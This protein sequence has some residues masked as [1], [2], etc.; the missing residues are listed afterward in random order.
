MQQKLKGYGRKAISDSFKFL[1]EKCFRTFSCNNELIPNCWRLPILSLILGT[2]I[3]LVTEYLGVLGISEEPSRLTKYAGLLGRKGVRYVTVTNFNLIRYNSGSLWNY[4]SKDSDGET[5]GSLS[6]A[7]GK[8]FC[9]RWSL[10]KS[11]LAI[12]LKSELLVESTINQ[13]Y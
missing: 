8:Q 10:D 5:R 11:F 2:K 13:N 1:C 12:V 6:T 4:L 3:W 9:I 7:R